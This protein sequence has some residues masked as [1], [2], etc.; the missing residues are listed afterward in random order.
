[1]LA[2]RGRSD[3]LAPL[4]RELEVVGC[5]GHPEDRTVEA[6]V[7]G[8]GRQDLETEPVDV[9]RQQ[10]LELIGGSR[11]AE[12]GSGAHALIRSAPRPLRN[13]EQRRA[14]KRA[15]TRLGRRVF[16]E[17]DEA[18]WELTL[19][20]ERPTPARREEREEVLALLS[21]QLEEFSIRLPRELFLRTAEAALADD[22][23]ALVL[24][25]RRDG[26]P[27]GV[28]YLSFQWT[29]EGGGW[30]M[31]LE[32]LYVIPGLRGRGIGGQLVQ[33]ALDVARERECRFVELETETRLP[34]AANLYARAG[35]KPL[36]R[37][38]WSHE[39]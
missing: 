27:V 7:I 8:K 37:V 21:A 3:G 29:L 19:K 14:S 15:A 10:G 18:S 30:A 12:D 35:F 9:E 39:L 11:N 28:A 31:W 22:G 5:S 36:S 32:E 33:A 17:P 25:A 2:T 23:R 34:R 26:R 13:P 20:S 6:L 16:P 4:V 38:H 1:M 24:V